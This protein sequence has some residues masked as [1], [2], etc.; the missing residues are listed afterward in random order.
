MASRRNFVLT[1]PYV[2][3]TFCGRR[4]RNVA[5]RY[6]SKRYLTK[7][8]RERCKLAGDPGWFF[9]D[10]L[11][12]GIQWLPAIHHRI[13]S[14][15]ALSRHA[16]RELA[17]LDMRQRSG[18]V[19]IVLVHIRDITVSNTVTMHSG[20]GGLRKDLPQNP[21]SLGSMVEVYE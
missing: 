15:G 1:P 20:R 13:S 12:G 18:W 9:E 19:T 6:L 3:A 16:G 2:F 7:P 5:R 14:A 11:I 8:T 4:N 10:F 21:H 17:S